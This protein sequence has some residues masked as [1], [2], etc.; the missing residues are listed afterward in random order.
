MGITHLSSKQWT[1]N[2]N[3]CEAWSQCGV[4]YG[5]AQRA[6]ARTPTNTES[7]RSPC[8]M[9]RS[10]I[11]YFFHITHSIIV[12]FAW[13]LNFAWMR[14]LRH[15]R[16]TPNHQTKTQQR[17]AVA[18]AEPNR[19]SIDCCIS[20]KRVA[21]AVCVS[22]F[23]C[24]INWQ[25]CQLKIDCANFSHN[26]AAIVTYNVGFPRSFFPIHP[27]AYH[28][29]ITFRHTFAEQINSRFQL[30][31]ESNTESIGAI[32]TVMS[33]WVHIFSL[34]SPVPA[35]FTGHF[36]GFGFYFQF[37]YRRVSIKIEF[38][39]SLCSICRR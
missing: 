32:M 8:Q 7:N 21:V 9:Y 1:A 13:N 17:H 34:Y 4:L 37:H 22:V 14:A 30:K 38:Y 12:C 23:R 35:L 31:I 36:I 20:S 5:C 6:H 19:K 16:H 39:D 25:L 29:I 18:A 33:F 28:H 3:K 27:I 24:Q 15:T 10:F 2:S 26:F 11:L